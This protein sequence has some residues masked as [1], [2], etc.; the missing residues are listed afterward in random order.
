MLISRPLE[1]NGR[2]WGTIFTFEKEGDVFPIHTH[3]EQDNHIT[4]LAFGKIRC[5][6]HPRYEGTVLEAQP[7]GTIVNWRVGEPH[8]FV[9]IVDGATIVNL[10]KART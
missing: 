10:V 9:A 3:T 2:S 4:I 7:G 8:G 5:M 1:I 6:G